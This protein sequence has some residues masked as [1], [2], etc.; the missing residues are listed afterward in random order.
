MSDNNLRAIDV[1]QLPF[2]QNMVTTA[3]AAIMAGGKASD[4]G[5]DAQKTVEITA[6]VIAGSVLQHI[7]IA[8]R[9]YDSGGDATASQWFKDFCLAHSEAADA[10][11]VR[12]LME[13]GEYP[14]VT[15]PGVVGHA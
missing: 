2:W 13:D 6:A 12:E 5:M 3:R 4:Q 11:S 1:R 14:G 7:G 8:C 9:M 15:V 10:E